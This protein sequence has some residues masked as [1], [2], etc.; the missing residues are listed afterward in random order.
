MC[1][2]CETVTENKQVMC[3]IC[4]PVADDGEAVLDDREPFRAACLSSEYLRDQ[5][6]VDVIIICFFCFSKMK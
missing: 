1:M 5:N 6:K 4:V 2:E 3:D